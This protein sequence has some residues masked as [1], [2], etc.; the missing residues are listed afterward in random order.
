M[1]HEFYMSF[2]WVIYIYIMYLHILMLKIH[3]KWQTYH[4][5]VQSSPVPAFQVINSK[6]PDWN[7]AEVGGAWLGQATTKKWSE[8]DG[9]MMGRPVVKPSKT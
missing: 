4:Q 7:S 9:E 6:C 5:K 1:S 3:T 2:I 8:N